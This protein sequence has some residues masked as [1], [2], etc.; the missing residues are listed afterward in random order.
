MR[1]R[2]WDKYKKV[3]PRKIREEIALDRRV[4]QEVGP[5]YYAKKNDRFN[6]IFKFTHKVLNLST[7]T[8][9]NIVLALKAFRKTN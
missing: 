1:Q 9:K 7:Q 3:N 8:I 4:L 2:S 5:E 6:K